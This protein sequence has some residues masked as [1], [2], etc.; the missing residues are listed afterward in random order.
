MKIRQISDLKFDLRDLDT[1]LTDLNHINRI[2]RW[3]PKPIFRTLDVY[4][5][6][7]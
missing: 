5:E 6:R 4:N 2:L 3:L 7:H 1:V